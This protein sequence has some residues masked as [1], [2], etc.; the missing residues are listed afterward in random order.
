M[1]KFLLRQ[2]IEAIKYI[3]KNTDCL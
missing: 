1:N 2:V 3:S